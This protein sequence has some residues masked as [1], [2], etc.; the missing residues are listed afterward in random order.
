[1]ISLRSNK[2]RKPKNIPTFPGVYIFRDA[3][4]HPLYVGK[5]GNLK[6]RLSFYFGN[7]AKKHP[8]T[9]RLLTEATSVS[10]VKTGSE[11]EALVEE[12]RLI[13]TFHPKYNIL[14]RDDK[15]YL[16]VVITKEYFPQIIL[17]H[18]PKSFTGAK[19]IIGPFTGASAVKET[20]KLLRGV[21]PYCTCKKNHKNPCLNAEIGKCPGVCC[22]KLS[23]RVGHEILKHK[24]DYVKNIANI[25]ALLEGKK[26]SALQRKLKNELARASSELKYE[27][28][29]KLRDQLYG[30]K[31]ILLHRSV[32][33]RWTSTEPGQPNGWE[34]I[35]AKIKFMLRAA[36]LIQRVEGYD[37][38][39]ISGREASGS[40]VVFINGVPNKNEYRKFRIKT[41]SGA[42]DVAMMAEII[43]RR[44][45][46]KEWGRADLIIL[47][48]GK[49][50]L[51]TILKKLKSERVKTKTIITSLAKRDEELYVTGLKKPIQ[52]KK[53]SRELLH[54]FQRVRD[55]AHRFAK[56]YHHKLREKALFKEL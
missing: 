24:N 7:E 53:A 28:A 20:L 45:R 25:A 19:K 47:D 49:P 21:F 39:N 3:K 52:L 33:M 26:I 43:S 17:T 23:K 10:I 38:S 8:R 37:I 11:I 48:G 34:A 29:A 14:M 30:L 9:E 54:F 42:N 56:K 44:F 2:I 50:Q 46:H 5:A 55:E 31:E 35:R 32:I 40:M 15:N 36:S 27:Q 6:S 12:A 51:N 16:F 4:K 13:K 1:M 41:V 18:Q 22:E